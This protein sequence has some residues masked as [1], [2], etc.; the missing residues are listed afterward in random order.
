MPESL[1]AEGTM[2]HMRLMIRSISAL[3]LMLSLASY[4]QPKSEIVIS[5]V[6]VRRVS[7]R[8]RRG[9]ARALPLSEA[10]TRRRLISNT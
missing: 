1:E 4:I 7:G 2:N 5:P 8:V 3:P 6:V 10:F 9:R